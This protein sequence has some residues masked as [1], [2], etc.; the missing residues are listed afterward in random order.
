LTY[1]SATLK[2]FVILDY[3]GGVISLPERLNLLLDLDLE[4]EGYLI[5]Y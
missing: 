4:L 2:G 5:I 1:L 3:L